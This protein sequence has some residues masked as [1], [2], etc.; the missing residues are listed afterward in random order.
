MT[1]QSEINEEIVNRVLDDEVS[2]IQSGPSEKTE[3]G[4]VSTRTA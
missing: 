4:D 2:A 1:G 3:P